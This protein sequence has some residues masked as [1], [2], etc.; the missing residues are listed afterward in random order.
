MFCKSRIE[1]FFEWNVCNE[2][3][4]LEIGTKK[5]FS[6]KTV[7]VTLFCENEL[8]RNAILTFYWKNAEKTVSVKQKVEKF[9]I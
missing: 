5:S 9:L 7:S 8:S 4:T 1:T 6:L 3:K 2:T